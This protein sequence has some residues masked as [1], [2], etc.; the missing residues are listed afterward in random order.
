MINIEP[1]SAAIQPKWD[2]Y[3]GQHS[4]SSPYHLFAWL[5]SVKQAYGHEYQAWVARNQAQQI[6]GI[7]ASVII[8][9]P[10]GS[11]KL[12]ALPFCDMGGALADS[13][14]IKKQLIQA[15][16]DYSQLNKLPC[17]EHRSSYKANDDLPDLS[18]SAKVRMLIALPETSEALLA[19]FKSKLRSQIKKSEKNGLTFSIGH[20]QAHLEGFY[21]VFERNMRDLGSPV[22]SKTWFQSLLTNYKDNLIISNVY[23][24]DIV[25]GAGIVLRN[26]SRCSIPWASTHAEYNRLAPNMLLYWSLLS[27][28]TDLGI[29]QFDFGRSK[30]L[31]LLKF[32]AS[33]Y[34]CLHATDV[35][36]LSP[37]Q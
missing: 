3:V 33:K 23:K 25:I 6:V 36:A 8:K 37:N 21:S 32:V 28:V 22:H 14:D 4:E 19:S 15:A 16:V 13:D 31:P 24:D 2:E 29:Q 7:L 18:E 27:H 1:V 35:L 34:P 26:Q 10:I 11:G 5:L 17:F 12:S 30:Q 20:D 9:P